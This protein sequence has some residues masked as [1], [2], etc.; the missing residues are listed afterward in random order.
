MITEF[1]FALVVG[2]FT[3]GISGYVGSLM[4][5][6][7]I[8]LIGGPLGHLTLPGIALAFYYGFDVSLG[9]LLF[10]I[11]GTSLIWILHQKTKLPMEAVTATVFASS[12]A[13]AFLILPKKKAGPAIL[14]DLSQITFNTVL[15]TAI[16]ATIVFIVMRYLYKNMVLMSVSTDLAKTTGVNVTLNNFIFL[17]CIALTIALAVRIVGGL[18]T[19]ALVAIPACTS[20]NISKSL[21]QYSYLSLA[22]GAASCLLGILVSI[23]TGL[24]VGPMIIISST[25][26]FVVSVFV[27]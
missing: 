19:A 26:L 11:F 15:I 25:A 23:T 18:M 12:L 8:S 5:T 7:R 27:H 24:P 6:K 21:M 17:T 2:L 9:A 14:G 16:T 1:L 4:L 13:V 22:A 20:R 10:L 3:G